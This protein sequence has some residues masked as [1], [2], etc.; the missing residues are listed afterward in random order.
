MALQGLSKAGCNATDV[1][2]AQIYKMAGNA[3]STPVIGVI[4]WAAL[5]Q[6]NHVQ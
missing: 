5:C 4:L 3:M 1:S 2:D 6:L